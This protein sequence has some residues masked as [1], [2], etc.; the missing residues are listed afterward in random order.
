MRL[1][2]LLATQALAQEKREREGIEAWP[3][4]S[5]DA[6]HTGTSDVKSQ[7][8]HEIRWQLPVDLNPQIDGGLFIHYGS[9]LVTRENTVIVPV[10]TGAFD[11][12]RIEAHSGSDGTLKW[13][14][15]SD[16]SVPFADFTPPLGP[17]LTKDRIALPA[18]GGTVLIRD[19]VELAQGELTSSL[20]AFLRSPGFLIHGGRQNG[21]RTASEGCIVI[22]QPQRHAICQAGG[23]P[24][25]CSQ[26]SSPRY[27]GAAI[28]T[29]TIADSGI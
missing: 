16:Y 12:Y 4:Q 15:D 3:S 11:G 10:K 22:G 23:G 27:S 8:L 6:Q 17:V 19:H 5:H 21:A 13:M 18:A 9:P 14:L 1:F 28:P 26:R 24:L 2:L 29:C 7:P 25:A 20:D